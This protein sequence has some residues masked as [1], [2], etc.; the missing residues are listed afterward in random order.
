MSEY[1]DKRCTDQERSAAVE[2]LSKAMADGQLTI[3]QSSTRGRAR[4]ML[5]PS[6]AS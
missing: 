4:R 6:V 5:R 1:K 2:A 3:S